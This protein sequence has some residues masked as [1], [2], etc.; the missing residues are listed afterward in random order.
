[1]QKTKK[2][3]LK[4]RVTKKRR[5]GRN[6]N[7]N[8][9]EN[10]ANARNNAFNYNNDDENVEPVMTNTDE[11]WI[12]KADE[13]IDQ[14]D[15]SDRYLGEY[16]FGN[17][18][19]EDRRAVDDAQAEYLQWRMNRDNLLREVLD[20]YYVQVRKA[21][22]KYKYRRQHVLVGIFR[23]VCDKL[24]QD[25]RTLVQR[26]R[27]RNIVRR[28]SN[29]NF[30]APNNINALHELA[31]A[32]NAENAIMGEP[33]HMN[34]PIMNFNDEKNFNRYYQNEAS[35]RS[36]KNTKKNPFTRKNITK[37]SWYKPVRK[38][39]NKNKNN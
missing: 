13:L 35:I 23:E 14:G 31:I 28:V 39:K 9:N 10:Y 19:L 32:R 3:Q 38:N 37:I 25:W 4:K 16:P 20:G 17:L 2:R 1:M 8:N 7:N 11:A 15:I 30:N 21:L 18:N 24:E 6:N 29:S 5:G 26:E 12:A 36:L 22:A 33:I 34:R 27:E